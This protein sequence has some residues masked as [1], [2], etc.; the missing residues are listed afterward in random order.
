MVQSENDSIYNIPT[1]EFH[2]MQFSINQSTCHKTCSRK[3]ETKKIAGSYASLSR[4]DF[5]MCVVT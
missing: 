1:S 5:W 3:S 2:I 4:P